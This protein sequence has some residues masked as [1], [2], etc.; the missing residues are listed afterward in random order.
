MYPLAVLNNQISKN[1][2]NNFFL[3]QIT[4][5]TK[6]NK[7][8]LDW[9]SPHRVLW[10]CSISPWTD[11]CVTSRSKAVS[12]LPPIYIKSYPFEP[13]KKMSNL[14]GKNKN[15]TL[16]QKSKLYWKINRINET[17]SECEELNQIQLKCDA[18]SSR[19]EQSINRNSKNPENKLWHLD[20]R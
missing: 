2:T 6:N 3:L 17:H 9:P 8:L 10:I 4:K 14:Q 5:K 11:S 20:R 12:T 13:P 1:F 7:H 15:K 19:L 16:K 18:I